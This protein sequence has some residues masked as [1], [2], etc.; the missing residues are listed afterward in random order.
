MRGP[1]VS[2]ASTTSV[3]PVV[4]EAVGMVVVM[5]RGQGRDILVVPQVVL[6]G[7]MR[8]MVLLVQILYSVQLHLLVVV[9]A[10]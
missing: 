9:T 1:R 2:P 10:R 6:A 8:R 3:W 5:G 4:L 7:V